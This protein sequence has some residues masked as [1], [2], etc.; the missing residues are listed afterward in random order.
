ML[1]SNALASEPALRVV[2]VGFVHHQ[3][4][5]PPPHAV[6]TFWQRPCDQAYM[7]GQVEHDP[8]FVEVMTPIAPSLS[9]SS[10]VKILWVLV[11]CLCAYLTPG[12]ALPKDAGPEF[13]N[14]TNEVISIE[15]AYSQ[16]SGFRGD[17]GAGGLIGWPFA[18]Q[19]QTIKVQLKNGHSLEVSE[20]RAARLCAKLPKPSSQVWVIDGSRIC[21][22]DSRRFKPSKGYRCTM[23]E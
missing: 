8:S 7:E 12:R 15:I 9:P 21:V 2:H 4:P 11:M 10:R 13:F 6:S 17:I 20:A 16:G 5:L 22:V 19:V 14:A 18:W 23:T 1:A 3:A